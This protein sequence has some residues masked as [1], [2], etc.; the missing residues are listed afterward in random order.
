VSGATGH[1]QEEEEQ[2]GAE[3]GE[4]EAAAAR[5][6]ARRARAEVAAPFAPGPGGLEAFLA[7]IAGR[8]ADTDAAIARAAAYTA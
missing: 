8:V 4:F 1:Q 5:M 7:R 2:E 3:G 6:R